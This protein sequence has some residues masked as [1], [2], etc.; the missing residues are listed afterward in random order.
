MCFSQ[1]HQKIISTDVPLAVV[2]PL[3]THL[4]EGWGFSK[5]TMLKDSGPEA[6]LQSRNPSPV[7]HIQRE[8]SLQGG[9]RFQRSLTHFCFPQFDTFLF[10]RCS[11]QACLGHGIHSYIHLKQF[12]ICQVMSFN[13]MVCGSSD[14][15]VF[16]NNSMK[17]RKGVKN[18]RK[19]W[20]S[21]PLV[22]E[23][24]IVAP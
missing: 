6:N 2:V 8:S 24:P 22:A 12:L 17:K 10:S 3:N 1:P 15:I 5:S 18:L 11:S 13:H 9:L 7:G 19:S 23:T 20:A 4:L 21:T 16:C 14:D